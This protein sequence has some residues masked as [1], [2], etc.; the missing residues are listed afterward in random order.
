MSERSG[1]YASV[2]SLHPSLLSVMKP[3]EVLLTLGQGLELKA[4]ESE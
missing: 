3:G 4:L 2:A 1:Q